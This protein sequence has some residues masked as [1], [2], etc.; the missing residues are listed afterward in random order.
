MQKMNILHGSFIFRVKLSEIF[1][2]SN[3]NIIKTQIF[4][5]VQNFIEIFVK[6]FFYPQQQLYIC[7]IIL[8]K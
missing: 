7:I 5:P 3:K 8:V 4:S 6:I 2:I 1:R